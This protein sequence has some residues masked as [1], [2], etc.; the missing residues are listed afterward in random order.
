MRRPKN[1]REICF[2]QVGTSIERLKRR[3]RNFARRVERRSGE[4]EEDVEE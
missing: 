1:K 3:W 4:E 2:D